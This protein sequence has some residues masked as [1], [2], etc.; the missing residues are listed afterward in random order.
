MDSQDSEKGFQVAT[1]LESIEGSRPTTN[2]SSSP[3]AEYRRE[4]A[5]YFPISTGFTLPII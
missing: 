2:L 1:R 4:Y 5:F 3:T